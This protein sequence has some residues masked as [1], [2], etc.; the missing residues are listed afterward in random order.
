M[1]ELGIDRGS[2][3]VLGLLPLVYVAWVHGRVQDRERRLIVDVARRNGWLAGRG[4]EILEGWLRQAPSPEYLQRGLELLGAL[5]AQQ[6][7]PGSERTGAF[8]AVRTASLR[9]LV[10]LCA[11]LARTAGSHFGD[12]EAIGFE[13]EAALEDIAEAL[14][15]DDLGQRDTDVD[16]PGGPAPKQ[17]PGP[18]GHLLLGCMP[19]LAR[20]PLAFLIGLHRHYGDIVRFQV[21]GH[22]LVLL[23]RP[24][25]AAHVL[26]DHPRRYPRSAGYR[27]L[28]EAFGQGLLTSEGE[29]WRQLRR[30]TQPAYGH[31]R[32]GGYGAA[33]TAEIERALARW[34]KCVGQDIDVADELMKLTLAIT[35]RLMLGIDLASDDE[36]ARSVGLAIRFASRHLSSP[37]AGLLPTP[38]RSA[39]LTAVADF[40]ALLTTL[41]AERRREGAGR[42][43]VLDMLLAARD[44]DT[45]LELTDEQV[46]SELLTFLVAAHETTSVALT[47]AL[48][49]LSKYP[50]AARRARAEIAAARRSGDASG[51]G[52]TPRLPFVDMVLEESLR[53]YPPIYA[54]ARE[55]AGDDLVG[56]FAIASG[57]VVLLSPWILHRLPDVWPN[58]EG[59]D[60]ERFVA[61]TALLHKCAYVPF[62]G[63]P[64]KCVGQPLAMLEMRLVLAGVLS[65]FHLDL[66][67]SFEP[68]LES[69]AGMRPRN[70]MKMTVRRA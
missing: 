13:A 32:V 6:S 16:G 69:S 33:I 29:Q 28:S 26:V 51:P 42:R 54:L 30:R 17:P 21:P 63:G 23:A 8:P 43:D 35:G 57:T 49:L 58:P 53:L 22:T 66:A 20:D 55:A 15:L 25:H 3:R 44:E 46:R 18:E 24:E 2:A 37:L 59:F 9:G 5:A 48:Y 7:G 34:D 52:G 19:E 39:F 12:A 40:D 4:P 56:G 61:G 41:V 50:A 65:R 11:D 31:E 68:G 27:R 67:P 36:A 64:R 14:G 10:Q 62:A 47:W 60:P 1:A 38:D 45:G 70:G